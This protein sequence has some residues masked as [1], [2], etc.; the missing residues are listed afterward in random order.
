MYFALLRCLLD[1]MPGAAGRRVPEATAEARR[2]PVNHSIE[3]AIEAVRQD[4]LVQLVLPIFLVA[5]V[6]EAAWARWAARDLYRRRD[7]VVSL[8]M[9]VASIAIEILPKLGLVA[10]MFEI[11]AWSPLRDVVGRQAW[12]W[13]LLFFLDDL[14]YYGFHRLN[15]EVRLLWAGHVNHHSSQYMNLG[16][17]LRQGV[18]ERV[19]KL[20]FWLWLPA[21]GFD[22][23]M[24]LLM[25]G[26]NL[27]YQFWVHTQAVRRLPYG[28]E[29]IFNTPSHHR[30]HHGSNAR[31][32]DRNH[33]GVLIVWDKLFGTFA[34]EDEDEPVV[35]GLTKN[36]DGN[37]AWR[38]L[39]H[40]Y[41]DLLADLRRADSW[42]DRLRYV[43]E[44]PGWSHD[45]PDERA[46]TLRA[47]SA[48]STRPQSAT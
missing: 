18:G 36:V 24:V 38:V 22:P 44:P 15:H 1:W 23:A 20:V 16:T 19:Y 8:V 39:V 27:T 6:V 2:D 11:H 21:L 10:L 12:A 9:L 4:E 31:Y 48:G 35:Y 5:V 42:R 29:A 40:G 33:A 32:L 7:T 13:V 46:E 34:A 41:T 45:G 3:V 26:L 25:I 37:S 47:R 14:T 43:L 17:A 28:L 30:V